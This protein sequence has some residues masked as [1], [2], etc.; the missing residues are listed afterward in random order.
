M[1]ITTAQ[2]T[3]ALEKSGLL[4][5]DR[6]KDCCETAAIPMETTSSEAVAKQLVRSGH[7]T[8]FQAQLA[9]SGKASSL[10]IGSYV[11]LE[12]NA[13]FARTTQRLVPDRLRPTWSDKKLKR[14]R[15]S[16]STFM[17]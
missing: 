12:I 16:C 11:V 3:D 4:T 10:V 14:T 17:M 1:A 7:L 13:D 5:A 8:R 2:L 9:L 6:I 15:F